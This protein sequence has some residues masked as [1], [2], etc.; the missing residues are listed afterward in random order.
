MVKPM[1]LRRAMLERLEGWAAESDVVIPDYFV[2]P[3][4]EIP[5]EYT[6]IAANVEDASSCVHYL[7]GQHSDE[8][9]RLRTNCLFVRP[10]PVDES[11]APDISF[12]GAY[13]SYVPLDYLCAEENIARGIRKVLDGRYTPYANYYYAAHGLKSSR[14]VDLLIT[15]LIKGAYSYGT[16]YS[17]GELSV[18]EYFPTPL[19]VSFKT[20]RRVLSLFT[21]PLEEVIS[22][23]LKSASRYLGKMID[24]EFIIDSDQRLY[25]TQCREVSLQYRSIW[26]DLDYTEKETKP[27]TITPYPT[28][29]ISGRII[30]LMENL[31]KRLPE[32][33]EGDILMVSH[34]YDASVSSL[35][36]SLNG[37]SRCR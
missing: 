27:H 32:F 36:G 20:P 19:S 25:F 1:S 9:K 8:I 33:T 30:N 3:V 15:P 10:Q 21:S 24:I 37:A 22:S 28:Q 7:I 6:D 16:G 35:L 13:V 4:D 18:F 2:V 5:A 14:K 11:I 17:D 23:R 34:G 31:S 29:Q 26:C 12:A